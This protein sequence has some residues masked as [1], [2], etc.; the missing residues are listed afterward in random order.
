MIIDTEQLAQNYPQLINQLFAEEFSLTDISK[1]KNAFEVALS[2]SDGIYRAQGVP[3]IN[4]LIRTAS[5]LIQEKQPT[6]VIIVA[7]THAAFVIH[8]F[9]NSL[10]TS[11]LAPKRKTITDELNDNIAGMLI[12]YEQLHWYNVDAINEHIKMVEAGDN[13]NSILLSLRLANELEDN[14][15]F[16]MLYSSTARKKIRNDAYNEAC[17]VLAKRLKLNF[18]A[19]QLDYWLTPVSENIIP[20]DFVRNKKQGYEVPLN[21]IWQKN[22]LE[23]LQTL[24]KQIIRRL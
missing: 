20:L 6:D 23:K 7:L 19:Q 4:H 14:M 13:R 22:T 9:D 11:K 3:L 2:F 1:I 15:D 5:I 10:R 18:I 16:A 8:K 12:S 24:I 17:I 21:R